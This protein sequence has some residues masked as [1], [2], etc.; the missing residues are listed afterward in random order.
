[1]R[2]IA[3]SHLSYVVG[4]SGPFVPFHR[5]FRPWSRVLNRSHDPSRPRDYYLSHDRA[6]SN[7]HA[8]P[9]LEVLSDY[10]RSF[11]QPWNLG[12]DL[13]S[14]YA[15]VAAAIYILDPSHCLGP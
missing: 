10:I 8:N 1:M 7:S 14:Q 15:I 13:E 6:H 3:I 5:L 4:E 9:T 11:Y 12:K 2:R